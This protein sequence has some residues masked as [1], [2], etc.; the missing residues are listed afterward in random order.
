MD[1][2]RPDSPDNNLMKHCTVCDIL[3]PATSEFFHRT[4]HAK[5]GLMP[6][7]K[8]CQCARQKVYASRPETRERKRA[9]QK[10]YLNRPDVKERDYN[11]RIAYNN[12]PDVQERLKSYYSRPETHV[13]KRAYRSRPEVREYNRVYRNRP[14][15]R[16]RSHIRHHRRR[17]RN[18]AALGDYTAAQIQALLKKQK[19]CCYY[20]ACGHV[21]FQCVKGRYIYHIDHVI[22]LSRGGSNDISNLVLACPTCNLRKND[23]LPHEFFEGGR[24]L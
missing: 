16:E 19:H 7:C 13:L 24:L 2:L 8:K 4:K 9:R 21:R 6:L 1:I 14:E 18:K 22:P 10:A 5:C 12:R 11:Y 20:A 17:S 3:F 23:K 15:V